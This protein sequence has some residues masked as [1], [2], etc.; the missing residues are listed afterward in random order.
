MSDYNQSFLSQAPSVLL[1]KEGTFSHDSDMIWND[2][3]KEDQV[4][5]DVS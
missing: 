3:L 1:M 5:A 2:L 4:N